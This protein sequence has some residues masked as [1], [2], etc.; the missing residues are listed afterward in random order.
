M[1]IAEA[2]WAGPIEDTGSLAPFWLGL[3]IVIGYL[4]IRC[5]FDGMVLAI[6]EFPP[7]TYPLW[8]GVWWP[9]VVNA[10][11]VGFVP[12]ALL[13]A[14][15]GIDRD[16]DQLGPWLPRSDAAVADLRAAATGPL[17]LP[18]GWSCSLQSSVVSGSS[19]T[20]HP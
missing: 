6:W 19:S 3:S 18:A 5:V 7:G 9:E 8:Q 17:V 20:I 1:S 2:R 12:A 16:F 14:R 4:L 11:L 10:T 15:R 13:I